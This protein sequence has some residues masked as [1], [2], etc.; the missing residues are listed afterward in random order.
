[1]QYL[2]IEALKLNYAGTLTT[3]LDEV[4]MQY[5]PIEALKRNIN[6]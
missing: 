5:L 6:F 4:Q 2:P 1:M 3:D